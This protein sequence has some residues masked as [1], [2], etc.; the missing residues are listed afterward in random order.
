MELLRFMKEWLFDHINTVDKRY[1]K[2][3]QQAGARRTWLRK[4]W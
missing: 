1:T 2:D 4:F 3:F